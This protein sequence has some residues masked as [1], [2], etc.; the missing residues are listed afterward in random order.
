LIG[1]S[2]V[3]GRKVNQVAAI[4]LV[5]NGEGF[6]DELASAVAKEQSAAVSKSCNH[7]GDTVLTR[8]AP[9]G[10]LGASDSGNAW[11]DWCGRRETTRPP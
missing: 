2:F 5:A 8:V 7:C 11:F 3:H 1:G 10:Y 4:G 6:F 9:Y